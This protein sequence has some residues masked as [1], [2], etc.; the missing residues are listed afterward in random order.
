MK[1]LTC[2][3]VELFFMQDVAWQKLEEAVVAIQNSTSIKSALEDLYQAVQNLCSHSFAPLV[4]SKLKN[5]TGLLWIFIMS[6]HFICTILLL[7]YRIAR[8]IKPSTVFG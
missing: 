7:F 6:P 3:T 1:L 8:S 4:Y 5:L 2:L